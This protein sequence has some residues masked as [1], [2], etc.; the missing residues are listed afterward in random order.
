MAS[1]LRT[2][3]TS[4]TSRLHRVSPYLVVVLALAVVGG[5]YTAFLAPKSDAQSGGRSDQ[6]LA[7]KAGADLY[8]KGCSTCHGLNL[9]GGAGGPSLIGVGS[10]SVVFQMESGRMPLANGGVQA[11]RKDSKYTPEQIDQIAAFVQSHGGGA[12]LPQGSL[13][14]GDLA[15]GGELFRTNC[16][17]CHNFAGAG[18]ALTYGKYAPAL[19]ES[20]ARVIYSAML[21]GPENMPRFGN[22]QLS[23][24]DKKA[25]TYYVRHLTTAQAPGGNELG[26]FGPVSEGL[27]IWVVG[28]GALVGVTLWIGN[29]A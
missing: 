26:R 27:L 8:L 17:S 1:L 11:P 21:S 28:I 2:S 18:G 23:E 6:S 16:A 19:D 20:S 9:E 7:V 10:A 25:I 22:G 15:L 14:D 3:G 12:E 5:L 24:A 13:T 4:N 29:R